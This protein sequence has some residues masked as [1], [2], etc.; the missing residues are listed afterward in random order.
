MDLIYPLSP[1]LTGFSKYYP[2]RRGFALVVSLLLMSFL[3]LLILSTTQLVRTHQ[4]ASSGQSHELI[5]RQNA[6]LGVKMALGELQRIAGPDKV[7][8]APADI[9]DSAPEGAG[10]W[11]GVWDSKESGG[12]ADSWR[13]W[14]VSLPGSFA[15]DDSPDPQVLLSSAPGLREGELSWEANDD[16][17]VLLVGN[18]SVDIEQNSSSAVVAAK[19]ELPDDSNQV[20]NFAY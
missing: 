7:V 19:R 5:A 16:D 20:G 6:L 3:V 13:G 9:I 15:N 10:H 4:Q 14:L 2:P 11:L 17:W 8:T 18:G 12:R 1:L